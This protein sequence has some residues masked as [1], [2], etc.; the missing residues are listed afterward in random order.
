MENMSQGLKLIEYTAT[1]I[2]KEDETYKAIF[3]D[4]EGNG[5]GAIELDKAVVFTNYYTRTDN[6]RN[7]KGY[8]L[9]MIV[10][11]FTG[12]NR[13]VM[14]S[15]T[16]YLRRFLAITERKKDETWGT[17]WNIKHV[18][19]QFFAGI[20]AWVAENTDE[21]SIL[22][23]GDFEDI[24]NAW[25]LEGGA[26]INYS[27]RFS[28]KRGLYFNRVAGSASQKISLERGVYTFHFFLQGKVGVEISNLKGE[29]WDAKILEWVIGE[30]VI[31]EFEKLEW[32]D[33]EMFV[34]IPQEEG[35]A[36]TIKFISAEENVVLIDY[37]RFFHKLRYPAYTVIIQYD[38]YAIADKTLHLGK[39]KIDP[40]PLIT[41]YPRESYF[42]NSYIVGRVGAY[43]KEVYD[44]LLEIIRPL[45]IRAFIETV[46]KVT[47]D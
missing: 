15:D 21:L 11:E 33:C 42:D 18:F 30:G 4:D 29:Y 13:R 31:N 43:R 36:I 14:E 2:N 37:V 44:A 35:D 34:K 7:H 41:W 19:E 38:G 9:D 3:S 40:D 26:E 46:E 24:D 32:D 10:K 25:T 22:E 20:K 23:N 8:T 39:G 16:I 1:G 17:K 6:V 45:G 27:A 12:L 28:G 47:E 5:A